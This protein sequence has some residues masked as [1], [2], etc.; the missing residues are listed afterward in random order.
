MGRSGVRGIAQLGDLPCDGTRS[1]SWRR[2]LVDPWDERS[3][4][5]RSLIEWSDLQ[6]GVDR[7]PAVASASMAEREALAVGCYEESIVL[8]REL[9]EP[10][11]LVVALGELSN[12][13]LRQC[14]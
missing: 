11:T 1:A 3:A 5:P 13:A 4:S 2:S 10:W 8:F 12:T 7:S 6:K 14:V 9:G